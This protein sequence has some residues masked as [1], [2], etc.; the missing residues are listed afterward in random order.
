MKNSPSIWRFS[1]IY[2]MQTAN[3]ACRADSLICR[4]TSAKRTA[5]K[6]AR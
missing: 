3:I 1:F 4:A 2:S 5:N 6:E